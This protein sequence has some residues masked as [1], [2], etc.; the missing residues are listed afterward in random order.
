MIEFIS[1]YDIL[2]LQRKE[3]TAMGTLRFVDLQTRPT[4]VLDL[5]SLTLD[6]FRQLVPPFETTFQAHMAAWRLDGQP[7]TARRYTTYKNCP[8]PTPED[9]LLFILVYLKTYPLQV[10]QGRLFGMGQS[11]AHQWLHVLLTVLQATLRALGDAPTRSVTGL[12]KRLGMTEADANALV[13]SVPEPRP[14]A[15]PPAPT[16]ARVPASPLLGMMA[17]NGASGVPRIRLSRRAVIAARKSAT[18][19]KT[20]C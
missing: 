14:S 5:T 9:R 12:A 10:V 16:S 8:L 19:S 18:R 6:E 20:C 1:I 13:V 15:D 17:P 3:A 11:K 4:E 7:R 2:G